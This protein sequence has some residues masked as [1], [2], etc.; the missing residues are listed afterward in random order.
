[1]GRK[2]TAVVT[3]MDIPLGMAVGNSLEVIEAVETLKGK[4]PEDLRELSL[5]LAARMLEL[6]GKGSL[7][8]CLELAEN[9]LKSGKA[10]KN[11]R[12]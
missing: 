5:E 4:G 9:A 11:L 1:M 8:Q 7:A 3:D 12:K 6:A 2:T 10:L